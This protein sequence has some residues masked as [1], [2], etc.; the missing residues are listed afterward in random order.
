MHALPKVITAAVVEDDRGSREALVAAL[1]AVDGFHCSG[2]FASGEEAVVQLPELL[3]DVVLMDI[4][5][6][7]WNGIETIQRLKEKMPGSDFIMLTVLDDE[8]SVF[9]SLCAGASGYL[10]KHASVMEI[11]EA[12]RVVHEG[13]AAIT[14]DIARLVVR[15]FQPQSTPGLSH[16]ESEVL[17]RL[18]E[19]ENYRSIAEALFISTNTVKAHIKGIYGKLHVNTRA[20]A[21][22]RALRDRLV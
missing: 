22:K 21:V 1:S 13:G 16:R 12:I 10:L 7:G 17:G 8:E 11:L 19:G 15:S 14:P 20:G 5:L 3:P 18:C 6:P 2:A 4:Q 9:R